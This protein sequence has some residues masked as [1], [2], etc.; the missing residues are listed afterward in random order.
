MQQFN[1]FREEQIETVLKI[2]KNLKYVK[3][4]SN[5]ILISIFE[6]K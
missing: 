3:Y 5:I 1:E 4:Q 6:G 2:E